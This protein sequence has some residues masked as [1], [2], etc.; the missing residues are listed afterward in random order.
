MIDLFR[1]WLIDRKLGSIISLMN[2]IDNRDNRCEEDMRLISAILKYLSAK[3]MR[4]V[5]DRQK[6]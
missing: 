1:Y 2:K 6:R 3:L 5:D 4:Y